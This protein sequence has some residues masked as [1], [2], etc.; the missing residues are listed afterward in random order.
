MQA[1]KEQGLGGPAAQLQLLPVG[2]QR[3]MYPAASST[4]SLV[5]AERCQAPADCCSALAA[6]CCMLLDSAFTMGQSSLH[7]GQKQEQYA[8]DGQRIRPLTHQ[9]VDGRSRRQDELRASVQRLKVAR[10]HNT[11]PLLPRH[12]Q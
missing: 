12:M 10:R 4:S 6:P 1:D 7:A 3:G 5:D 11:V 9:L 8:W 2:L